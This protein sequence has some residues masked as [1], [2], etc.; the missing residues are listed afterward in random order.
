MTQEKYVLV[1]HTQEGVR[2]AHY[3][4]KE[5]NWLG[6]RS[7]A[8]TVANLKN[9]T[10]W[11]RF[12]PT[13]TLI[14]FRTASPLP[15]RWA[16]KL[17]TKGYRVINS[18]RTLELTSDKFKSCEWARESGLALP[19]TVKVLKTQVKQSLESFAEHEFV[20]KPTNSKS[21]GAFCFKTSKADPLFLEKVAQ[22]PGKEIIFQ[23]LVPYTKIYRVI[24]INGKALVN[25]VFSDQ[26]SS[27]DWKVSVCLNPDIKLVSQPDDDLISYAEKLAQIY[28]TEIGFIDIFETESGEYILS[29]INTACNLW[30]HERLSGVNISKHI[31][32]YLKTQLP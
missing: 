26:P 31:A 7:Y 32:E 2:Y 29:E 27:E 22:V 3:I 25:A 10:D 1:I 9:K 19:K 8:Q 4:T 15:I 5:L 23:K 17:E 18:S 28:N 21:Q 12:T 6:I 13:N 30:N 20:I 11:D 14:H 16:R 24:V